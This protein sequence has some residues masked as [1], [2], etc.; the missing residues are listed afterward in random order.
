MNST[1][2]A[3]PQAAPVL[4]IDDLTKR[5]GRLLALR[6]V[7]LELFAGQCLTLFGRNGAGKSTLLNATASLIRSYEGTIALLGR[8]LRK[9]DEDTR[10]AVGLV[11]HDTY[12]YYDLSTEDNLRFYARLYD[13]DGVEDRVR[14][15][16]ER[17]D[18]AVKAKAPARDLSR[19]MKQRLSLAR[20]FLH[21]P[22]ILLLDEP[23]TGLD[24]PGCETLSRMIGEFV[25]GGG[26]ALVTTHDL[27]RG[28]E[29]ATR[30]AVLERGV[31]AYEADTGGLDR[32]SFRAHYR[33]LLAG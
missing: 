26:A 31:I 6:S 16:L 11:S 20:V 4:K 22:K 28:L 7:S 30:V 32:D 17:F 13:L 2:A 5:F 1:E 8:D 23:F 15:M 24:E 25:A 14:A 10:R 21:E 3:P 18:I 27:D 29:V 19:G 9:G 33:G 12:L